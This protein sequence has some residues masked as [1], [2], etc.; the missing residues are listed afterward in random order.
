MLLLPSCFALKGEILF[1]AP[2]KKSIQKKGD[3]GGLPASRVPCASRKARRSRN[4]LR[5]NKRELAPVFTAM[6]GGARRGGGSK[7]KTA[8]PVPFALTEYRSHS[9]IKARALFEAGLSAELCA[10][11]EWRGTHSRNSLRSNRARASSGLYCDARLRQTG[12]RVKTKI[13]N[14]H[15][16]PVCT[17]R[18]PQPVR[19]QARTL[20]EA[21]LPAELCAP[22][23]WRGTHGQGCE[24][25]LYIKTDEC[26]G[27]PFS[28]GTFSW[29]SKRKY[30]ALQ[31]E[32]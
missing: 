26:T 1:F 5:S 18:V 20:S 11:P 14:S 17:H 28:L 23:E 7:S 29:A 12:L 25:A 24:A 6:L 30:L 9:G 32:T 21:G 31:G 19:D 15:P 10:P 22:P 2:P 8:S 27:V 16:G 4:S 13:K 3:P